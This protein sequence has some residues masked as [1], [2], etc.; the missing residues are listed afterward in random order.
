MLIIHINIFYVYYLLF[1]EK[2]SRIKI[3]GSLRFALSFFIEK[4]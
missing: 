4:A 2:Y 1:Y 3:K